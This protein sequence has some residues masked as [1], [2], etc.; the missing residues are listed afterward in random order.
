ML[1]TSKQKL[2]YKLIS[3]LI[4]GAITGITSGLFLSLSLGL[5][6]GLLGGAVL[7]LLYGAI[8]G[9][10]LIYPFEKFDFSFSKISRVKFL[11]ELRQNLAPFAMAGIFGGII[12]ERLNGQPG[13]SLF[14]LSVCLFIGIFYSLINGFKIDISI[15]SR[16]N[17]GILRSARKVFPISLIIYPFAVFLILE[18][19][20]LRGSTLSLSFDFI[21]SEA[22]LLR[23]LL[24]SLGISISIGIY[25]GGGLAVV[26]HI[27]LRLT[28]WFSKAI[29]WDYAGFLNYCTERLLLQRV[30]GRYRFIHKLVQEHFASMPME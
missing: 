4:L 13:R 14:G 10:D 16:P 20:F 24:E 6:E 3:G 22:N 5:F 2:F 17:E 27:A 29:P 25:L 19:V 21:N 11:Q 28:L 18:S 15:P 1:S 7:G 9:Q 26:Q 8:G 23:V 30:G 12:L